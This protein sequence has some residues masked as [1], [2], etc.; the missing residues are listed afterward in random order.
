MDGNVVRQRAEAAEFVQRGGRQRGAVVERTK[1]WHNG[2]N[3]LQR[4]YER[5]EDACRFGAD[6]AGKEARPTG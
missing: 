3:R 4:C 1:P 5:N 2:F 6:D